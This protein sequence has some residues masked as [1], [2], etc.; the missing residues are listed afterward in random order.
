MTRLTADEAEALWRSWHESGDMHARDRLVLA[1]MPI[2]RWLATRKVRSLPTQYEVED[3]VSCGMVALLESVDLFDPSRGAAF[4][5]YAWTR[6][7]GAIA[8]ELRRLDWASRSERQELRR[9]EDARDDLT[10]RMG[11]E[12]TLDELADEL[13]LEP[14]ELDQRLD[15]AR[16]ADV[17]S[18]NVTVANGNG[19]ATAELAELIAA[20]EETSEP[21][22]AVLRRERLRLM[23]RA[24]ARLTRRERQALTLVHVHGVSAARVGRALGVSEARVSRLLVSARR[25]LRAVLGGRGGAT[26]AG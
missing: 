2:P 25:K 5:Q 16:R 3:L 10:A 7:S 13:Q 1:H 24:M 12:P 21:E 18:L 4:D 22:A 15:D 9:I 19:T 14:A 11:A 8:D 26:A 17:V 6:V 23:R 20:P